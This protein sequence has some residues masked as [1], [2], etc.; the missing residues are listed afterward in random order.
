VLRQKW[1]NLGAYRGLL[2]DEHKL[3]G[4]KKRLRKGLPA[5]GSDVKSTQK[6]AHKRETYLRWR[7]AVDQA[8]KTVDSGVGIVVGGDLGAG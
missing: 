7:P 4:H 2:I 8:I 3:I 6:L 1:N 5:T